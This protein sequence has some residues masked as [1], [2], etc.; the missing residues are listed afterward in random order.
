LDPDDFRVLTAI[1]IGMKNH[2]IVPSEIIE[3]IAGIK[4]GCYKHLQKLNKY[5]LVW[6]D[7]NFFDGYKLNYTGYDFLAIQVFLKRRLIIGLGNIIGIGKESDIFEAINEKGNILVLKLHRLGR[8]SFRKI[9]EKRDYL[10]HRQTKNWLYFSRLSALTEFSYMQILFK[11]KF[12]VPKPIDHNRHAVLM[13]FIPGFMLNNVKKINNPEYIFNQCL[14][15]IIRLAK[16]GLIHCD[17]NEFNLLVNTKGKITLID[18]PQ[19]ISI[20]NNNAVKM[21]QQDVNCIINFFQKRYSY[22][23]QNIQNNK[24]I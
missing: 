4:S 7:S 21:F 1:E 17:F 23:P 22:Y 13:T 20:E 3:S 24:N 9:K 5:K 6:H 15:T 18:F 11:E 10:K 14:N 2:E 12:I 19:M 8:T 16:Y